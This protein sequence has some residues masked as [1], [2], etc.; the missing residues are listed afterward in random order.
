MRPPRLGPR[1]EGWVVAQFAVGGIVVALGAR[2]L[3]RLRLLSGGPRRWIAAALGG[4]LVAL[5]AWT[6][7]RGARDLGASLTPMPRPLADARLVESGIYARLRHPIYAGVI[8]LGFGWAIL[9]GSRPALVAAAAET[10]VFLAKTSVEEE[11]LR[12]RYP[13][14]AGYEARTHR[15]IP[16]VL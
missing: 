1:G 3:P 10:L 8:G 15:F 11:W 7:G 12:A 4:T 6:V 13:S 5:G 16:G 14:Y 2:R 9:T